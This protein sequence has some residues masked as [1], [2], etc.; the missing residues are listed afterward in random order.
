M[1]YEIWSQY[2]KVHR[3]FLLATYPSSSTVTQF[4]IKNILCNENKLYINK[5]QSFQYTQSSDLK[6]K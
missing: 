3:H 2:L 5:G 6:S 1:L 4:S